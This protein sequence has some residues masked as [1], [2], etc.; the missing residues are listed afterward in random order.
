MKKILLLLVLTTA[1]FGFCQEIEINEKNLS[2][3]WMFEDVINNDSEAKKTE[4]KEML[5][6][7]ILAFREDGTYTFEFMDTREGTWKLDSQ[8]KVITVKENGKMAV[9]TWTVH[10][11]TKNKF[12]A[13]RNNAAQKIVFK[14]G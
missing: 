7:T 5:E 1:Q 11:L 4:M 13:S 9:N 10:S 2:K 3:K 6:S 8:K 14:A 12:I